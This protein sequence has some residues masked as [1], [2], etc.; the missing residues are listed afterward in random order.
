MK[1]VLMTN[2][3]SKG[4]VVI[5]SEFRKSLGLTVGMPLAVFSNGAT[6]IIKPVDIPSVETFEQLLVESRSAAKKTGLKTSDIAK[7][8]KKVRSEKGRS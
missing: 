5:P 7:T 2:M 4:Q 3:S 6:L 8:I 1:K